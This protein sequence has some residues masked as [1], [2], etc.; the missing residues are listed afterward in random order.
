VEIL[1]KTPST[2][3]P[4]EMFTGDVIYTP[5]GEWHWHGTAPH[6]FMVHTAIWEGPEPGGEPES[7]WGD[8]VTEEEYRAH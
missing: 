3:G 7:E 6:H 2:K 5:P 4:A 1:T 8:H